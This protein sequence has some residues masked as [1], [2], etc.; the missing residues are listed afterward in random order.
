[1]DGSPSNGCY[2]EPKNGEDYQ[3]WKIERSSRTPYFKLMQKATGLYLN[4]DTTRGVYL[5][6]NYDNSFQNWV[7]G[8]LPL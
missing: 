8:Y 6:Q 3:L 4:A 1:L 5:N 2:L 7:V